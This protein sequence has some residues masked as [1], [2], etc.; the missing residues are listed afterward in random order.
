MNKN[1]VV[2]VSRGPTRF[3]LVY[4]FEDN[5]RLVIEIEPPVVTN[6]ILL[7]RAGLVTDKNRVEEFASLPHLSGVLGHC[8]NFCFESSDAAAQEGQKRLAKYIQAVPMDWLSMDLTRFWGAK[9]GK[10]EEKPS[11]SLKHIWVQ[12]LSDLAAKL[13]EGSVIS[14]TEAFS[15]FGQTY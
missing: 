12:Q 13:A 8:E 6:D 9:Q 4:T 10:K 1:L 11:V 15:Q 7:Y 3:S 2:G 14:G 5:S